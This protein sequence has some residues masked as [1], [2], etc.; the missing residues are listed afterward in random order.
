MRIHGGERLDLDGIPSDLAG[1]L[2]AARRA[3][4]VIVHATGDAQHDFVLRVIGAL[5]RENVRVMEEPPPGDHSPT[6]G[7]PVTSVGRSRRSR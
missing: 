3:S 6:I 7:P 1:V 2:A 5:A 4:G